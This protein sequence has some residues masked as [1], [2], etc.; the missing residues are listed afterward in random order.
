MLAIREKRIHII[1]KK[2]KKKRKR[3]RKRKLVEV[4]A[5]QTFVDFSGLGTAFATLRAV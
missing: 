2:K 5:L 3:K 4:S 1:E